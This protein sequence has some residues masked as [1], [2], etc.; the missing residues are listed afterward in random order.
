MQGFPEILQGVSINPNTR[1]YT[2]PLDEFEVDRCILDHG[3]SVV[4]PAVPGPS[5]LLVTAGNGTMHSA[6]EDMVSEGD[7]LFTPAN[8]QISVTAASELHLYR[9]GVN[10][11]I[12]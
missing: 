12:F 11:R 7:V 9:A 10:S 6:A 1:R 4:F 2:P 3:T 8:T 5:I